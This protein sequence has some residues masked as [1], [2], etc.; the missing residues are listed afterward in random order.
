MGVQ[1]LENYKGSH[2]RRCF[3]MREHMHVWAVGQVVCLRELCAHSGLMSV[4]A[5]VLVIRRVQWSRGYGQLLGAQRLGV[6]LTHK[7]HP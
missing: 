5:W 2:G 7:G 4:H 1:E 6:G 3:G